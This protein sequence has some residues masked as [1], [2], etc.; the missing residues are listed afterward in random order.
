MTDQKDSVLAINR[1]L[2]EKEVAARAKQL[3]LTYVDI[4]NVPINIDLLKII[5]DQEAKDALLMP[6]LRVGKKLRLA[7]F[8]IDKK[9]TKELVQQLRDQG[10]LLHL[11]LASLGGLQES[12]EH[13]KT[14]LKRKEDELFKS[15]FSE[16]DLSAYEQEIQNL[17]NLKDKL[18][19]GRAAEFL[20]AILVGAI[21]TGSSDI[22]F[23]PHDKI[24]QVR[25]RIDGV[26]QDI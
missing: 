20:N 5:T 22:H 8:D 15:Q 4:A 18:Q 10:Y 23:E 9:E 2:E 3:G 7:V 24:A 19:T 17:T 11:S 25:F 26:M 14:D 6:F 13:Y 16:D 1:E 21:K 12:F